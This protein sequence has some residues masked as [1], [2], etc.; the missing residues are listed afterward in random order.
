MAIGT[1]VLLVGLTFQ[2]VESFTLNKEV[3]EKMAESMDEASPFRYNPRIAI[4][5]WLRYAAL[6]AGAV[7]LLHGVALKK[8]GK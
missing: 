6:S 3:H 8:A 1:V 4:P 2:R 7:L 5:D